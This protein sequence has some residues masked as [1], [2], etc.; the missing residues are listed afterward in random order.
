MLRLDG[1]GFGFEDSA[2]K[3]RLPEIR[4]VP[5]GQIKLFIT[6]FTF[7]ILQIRFKEVL[8]N[9]AGRVTLVIVN[10]FHGQTLLEDR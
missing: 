4:F 5:S 8:P 10:A 1:R 6:E 3:I 7:S 9:F 2:L